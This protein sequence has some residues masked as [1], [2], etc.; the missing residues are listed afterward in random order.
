[1]RCSCHKAWQGTSGKTRYNLKTPKRW[2]R[3]GY[4]KVNFRLAVWW[5]MPLYW[6]TKQEN[7]S[8]PTGAN[9]NYEMTE[10][11]L[12]NIWKCSWKT[13]SCRYWFTRRKGPFYT[14]QQSYRRKTKTSF[15]RK[16]QWIIWS[17]QGLETN[18][19]IDEI[20]YNKCIRANQMKSGWCQVHGR[21]RIRCRRSMDE[22]TGSLSQYSLSSK[23]SRKDNQGCCKRW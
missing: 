17:I 21:I 9:L 15:I 6:T 2:R 18:I 23:I 7:R 19:D 8:N 14:V 4:E 11:T 20:N 13:P 5:S 12:Q 10:H 3:M 16:I 22:H 1:M